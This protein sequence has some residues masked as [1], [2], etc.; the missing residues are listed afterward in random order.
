VAAWARELPFF[1]AVGA[2]GLPGCYL[3][4]PASQPLKSP[5]DGSITAAPPIV[6]VSSTLDPATP[7]E[8]G[9]QLQKKIRGSVVLT[10]EAADHTAYGR[11]SPCLDAPITKYLIDLT[12]PRDGLRCRPAAGG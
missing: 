8:R 11:Q 6:I 9:T 2:T 1:G 7:Y 10:W 12:V 4:P 3:F 5:P